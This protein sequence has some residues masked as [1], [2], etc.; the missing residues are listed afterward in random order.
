L[1]EHLRTTP[2][3]P[4]LFRKPYGPGWALVGDAGVVM[5]SITAQGI[6]NALRDADRL[7]SA[8]VA[9]LGGARPLTAALAEHHRQR[10][11]AVR[12]M[13]DFTVGLTQFRGLNRVQRALF[14]A[15]AQQPAEI[16]RFFGALAGLTPINRYLSVGNAV[17]VLARRPFMIG[18]KGP[19][20]TGASPLHGRAAGRLP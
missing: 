8:V 5:D 4:N 9:G 17:R 2:D 3:Q 13:Y 7:A 15:I 1:V 12:A 19:E 18:V 10:D 6:S 16:E 14:T 20:R 11:G